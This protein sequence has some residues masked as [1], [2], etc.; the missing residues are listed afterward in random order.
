MITN[1][2]IL[3]LRSWLRINA[4]KITF[5][6]FVRQRMGKA[7]NKCEFVQSSHVN[8]HPLWGT[9]KVDEVKRK[10]GPWPR[11]AVVHLNFLAGSIFPVPVCTVSPGH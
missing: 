8:S 2:R 7:I 9:L 4:A 6:E 5:F 11:A 1:L 3:L 10:K